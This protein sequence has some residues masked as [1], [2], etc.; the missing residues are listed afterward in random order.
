MCSFCEKV[1]SLEM[2]ASHSDL[3][4][5]RSVALIDHLVTSKGLGDTYIDDPAEREEKV[6]PM[7]PFSDAK[8][9][10]LSTL[11][12]SGQR[13]MTTYAHGLE[14]AQNAPANA[15]EKGL[16]KVGTA[17]NNEP[18]KKVRLSGS[19]DGDDNNQGGGS[20]SS[21]NGKKVI[22]Q[23]LLMK[24]DVKTIRELQQLLKL[25]G[26]VEEYV[27]GNGGDVDVEDAE[28]AFE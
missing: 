25:L 16:A 21:S 10:P 28:F 14:L 18:I 4:M 24:V 19:D 1:A 27:N 8:E 22:I 26:E 2:V 11:T 23:K 17:L 9:G 12:L 6:G 7:L 3:P 20:G 13:T 5:K 15:T